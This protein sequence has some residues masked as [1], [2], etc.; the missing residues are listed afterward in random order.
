M[1]IG[2][3]VWIEECIAPR[4]LVWPQLNLQNLF[5]RLGSQ[6]H[7]F[8]YN[9]VWILHATLQSIATYAWSVCFGK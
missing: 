9:V 8:P 2:I 6:F 7:N 4:I 1:P 5:V 3:L